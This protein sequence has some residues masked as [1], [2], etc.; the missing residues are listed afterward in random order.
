MTAFRWDIEQ[1][2][3][4]GRLLLLYRQRRV[5]DEG[6]VRASIDVLDIGGWGMLAKA[7]AE[8]GARCTILDLFTPDQ[9]YPARVK[10]LPH[11]VG[12]ARDPSLF[13]SE[14]FD[15]VTCFEMLEHCKGIDLVLASAAKWLRHGGVLAG[16]MPIPGRTHAA[17]DPGIE[18]LSSDELRE[19]LDRACL[20][21]ERLEP[22]ASIE[23][24]DQPSSIYFVARK[25]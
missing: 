5:F 18:F 15:A 6:I 14:I 16:T 9:A 2:D 23:L 21:V 11:V 13:P 8:A 24:D 22:T 19:R 20:S 7:I 4:N 10:A 1:R 25:P 3:A 17:D 12:D